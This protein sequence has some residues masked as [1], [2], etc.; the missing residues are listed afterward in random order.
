LVQQ[1]YFDILFPTD[2][3]VVEDMYRA[4]TGRLT[5]VSTHEE[6]F[7]RWSYPEE[8]RMRSGED[9][10]LEWYRNASVLCSV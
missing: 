6:F 8:T 1:G 9:A 7:S 3:G 2:F 4:I 10:L 5:R